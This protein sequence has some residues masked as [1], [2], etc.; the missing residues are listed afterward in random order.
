V[1]L[2][3][4]ITGAGRT[5][6]PAPI[7]LSAATRPAASPPGTSAISCAPFVQ[8]TKGIHGRSPWRTTVRAGNSH[9]EGQPL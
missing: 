1:V 9:S 8:S 3:N 4:N 7:P 2:P 5:A 6:A